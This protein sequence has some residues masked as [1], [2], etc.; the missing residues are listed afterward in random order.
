[1]ASLRVTPKRVRMGNAIRVC[2][3]KADPSRIIPSQFKP[4]KYPNPIP[5]NKGKEKVNKPNTSARLRTRT[6]WWISTSR[7]ALNIR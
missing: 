6:N 3:A 4:N 5:S 2:E 1:M 7:P